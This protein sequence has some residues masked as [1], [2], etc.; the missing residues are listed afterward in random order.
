M[1]LHLT[2]TP[3]L[4]PNSNPSWKLNACQT[5]QLSRIR[6]DTQ[7]L[8]LHLMLSCTSL[9]ISH[10]LQ[11]YAKSV[12]CIYSA[13][14]HKNKCQQM[15]IFRKMHQICQQV[16]TN[17]TK[18]AVTRC[19][20][21]PLKCDNFNFG[22]VRLTALPRPS[23]W[24]GGVSLPPPQKATPLYSFAVSTHRAIQLPR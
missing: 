5:Y 1:D 10:S 22:W 8:R 21:L 7:A 23:S 14:N 18:N 3:N 17:V 16:L 12:F 6:R 20:N 9:I 24:W 4:K 15:Q 2:L 19:Q 11:K 13:E